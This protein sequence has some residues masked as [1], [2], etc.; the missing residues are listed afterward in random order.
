[1]GNAANIAQCTQ[2]SMKCS[3]VPGLGLLGREWTLGQFIKQCIS[4]ELLGSEMVLNVVRAHLVWAMIKRIKWPGAGTKFR[5]HSWSCWS[6]VDPWG[7]R[8]SISLNFRHLLRFWHCLITT[9]RS[10]GTRS[11]SYGILF[12]LKIIE[13]GCEAG[14]REEGVAE[15]RRH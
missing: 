14:E 4:R 7:S 9:R 8:G 5:R 3:A 1:M 6:P 11:N 12:V 15:R 2:E 13:A 10:L